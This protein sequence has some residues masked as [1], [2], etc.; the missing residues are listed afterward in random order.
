[1]D[2]QDR[3]HVIFLLAQGII[4]SV[5]V[6]GTF[7]LILNKQEIPGVVTTLDGAVIALFFTNVQTSIVATSVAKAINGINKDG[8]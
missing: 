4:A 1:M 7:L 8:I 2:T 3:Q 6:I 5:C